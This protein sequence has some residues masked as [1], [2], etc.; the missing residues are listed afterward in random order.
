[1]STFRYFAFDENGREATG[2]IE[3]ANLDEARHLLEQQGLHAKEITAI[4]VPRGAGQAMMSATESEEFARS[5]AH[6]SAANLSLATGLRAAADET[7]SHRVAAALRWLAQRMD[8]GRP[9]EDALRSANGMV[10]RPVRGLIAAAQGT[11]RLGEALTELVELHRENRA[12]RRGIS[13]IFGYPLIVASLASTL[14]LFILT[15][16]GSMFEHMF[17]EFQLRLPAMTEALFWVRH[18]GLFAIAVF[19]AVL[20]A[21]VILYRLKAGRAKW[22]QQLASMP[23][24]GPLWF[25]T[26]IADWT[27]MLGVLLKYRVPLPDALRLAA[28]AVRNP[29]VSQLSLLLAD[30]VARGRSLSQL[31]ASLK[32][33]P[34]TLAPLVRW[35][36]QTGTLADAFNTA[37]DMFHNRVRKRAVL[38]Q[39][40]LP[41]AL[42]VAIGC[43]IVFVVVSLFIPLFNLI[44]GLS[45]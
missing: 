31:V 22:Y 32:G 39:T 2:E 42:F 20:F 14:L 43:C 19:A 23:L 7:G 21:L 10:P 18:F 4:F 41:P 33:I 30:G 5:L 26:A 27:G 29:Y 37:R 40:L 36:E 8:E 24:F 17:G 35:G 11:G 13:G 25:W 44:Q 34:R 1:M 3:A 28:D 6:V 12:L 38:L 45:G 9:L 15:Y 16:I